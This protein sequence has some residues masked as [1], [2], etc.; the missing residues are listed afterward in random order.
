L[1]KKFSFGATKV[2]EISNG[3]EVTMTFLLG[4]GDGC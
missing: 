4:G 1:L 2:K 3:K